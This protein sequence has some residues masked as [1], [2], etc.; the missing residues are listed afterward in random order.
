M[1]KITD[2]A[3]KKLEELRN[4]ENFSS[5]HNVR[6]NVKGGGCS[7]LLYDLKF[8]DKTTENAALNDK[9]LNRPAPGIL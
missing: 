8:D 4:S 7:G 9:K 2:K 6:V 5:K 1:I 3:A